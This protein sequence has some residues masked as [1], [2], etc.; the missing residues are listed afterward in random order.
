MQA[1]CSG[2]ASVLKALPSRKVSVAR[3]L[4]ILA[5][6]SVDDRRGRIQHPP[7]GENPGAIRELHCTR[8]AAG[9][10]FS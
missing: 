6:I 3:E 2:S 8:I 9:S 7:V 1:V 4:L 5:Y 10:L